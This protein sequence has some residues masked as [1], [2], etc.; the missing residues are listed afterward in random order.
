[1]S[2]AVGKPANNSMQRAA[3]RASADAARQRSRLACSFAI[4]RPRTW[5]R[6]PGGG[7]LVASS[8]GPTSARR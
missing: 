7:E 8:T 1:M 3:L 4:I 5:A 2:D 6:P